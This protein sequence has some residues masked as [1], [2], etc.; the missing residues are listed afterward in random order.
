MR[1]EG[2][3]P[4]DKAGVGVGGAVGDTASGEPALT[5]PNREAEEPFVPGK[6][7]AKKLEQRNF[8]SRSGCLLQSSPAIL[9][10]AS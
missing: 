3:A 5:C 4:D 9:K 1:R 2:L 10:G 8:N 7:R 6:V